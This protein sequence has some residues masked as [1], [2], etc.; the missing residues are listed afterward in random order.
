MTYK[1]IVDKVSKDI[2]LPSDR[3]DKIYKA[4]WNYIRSSVQNLPLKEELT[5]E[6]FSALRTNFNIPSLGKLCLSYKDYLG[7]KAKLNYIKDKQNICL[8]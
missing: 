5:E 7:S 6:E 3:V 2:G 8:S 1:E 4:F